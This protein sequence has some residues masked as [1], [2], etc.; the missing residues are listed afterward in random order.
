ME[1][2][3]VN[4]CLQDGVREHCLEE[5]SAWL[6]RHL[7]LHRVPVRSAAYHHVGSGSPFDPTSFEISAPTRSLEGV[8]QPVSQLMRD[9]M[10][11]GDIGPRH[12]FH[13]DDSSRGHD[14]KWI[15]WPRKR[16][17]LGMLGTASLPETNGMDRDLNM[18][19]DPGEAARH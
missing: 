5:R 18:S 10:G 7:D 3:C 15:S 2:A 17:W 4:A 19:E 6:P 8:E 16:A 9:N 14:S 12:I 1:L 11:A 13:G